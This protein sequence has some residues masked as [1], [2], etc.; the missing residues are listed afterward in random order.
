[1]RSGAFTEGLA[2][3]ETARTQ[4]HQ[5]GAGT[6]ALE[7]SARLAEARVLAGDP[8]HAL[9]LLDELDAD[10]G[11][12]FPAVAVAR[13]RVRGWAMISL[14]RVEEASTLLLRAVD[15]AHAAGI[16]FEAVLSLRGLELIGG[17]DVVRHRSAA[18]DLAE[19][20]GIVGSPRVPV[21]A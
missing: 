7:T 1:M 18:D 21:L 4:F 8:E 13:L 3:L 15:D 16:P 11:S 20:L 19:R 10:P 17:P 2:L 9:D 6:F 5:L 14:G 12:S